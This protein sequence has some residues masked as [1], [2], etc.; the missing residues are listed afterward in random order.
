MDSYKVELTRSAE[1][2][3]RRI[4]KRYISR[5]FAAVE[6]LEEEPRPV[7]CTKLSGSDHT[8]RIRVGSYRVIYEIEDDRLVVLVIKIGHRK[9]VY[10]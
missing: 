5:V 7:G 10:Q 6:S 8:Y 9:D 1:K 4:D 2:D 3:L